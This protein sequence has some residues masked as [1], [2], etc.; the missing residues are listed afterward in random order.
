M[1]G[2]PYHWNTPLNPLLGIP[3]V[4]LPARR[5]WFTAR[6]LRGI[7]IKLRKARVSSI[8]PGILQYDIYMMAICWECG[9]PYWLGVP[10]NS[11]FH[12]KV[13]CVWV[14]C[15][16][17]VCSL[18]KQKSVSTRLSNEI[19]WSERTFL[20]LL[21]PTDRV[22]ECSEHTRTPAAQPVSV[23]WHE[24]PTESPPGGS[25]HE[26]PHLVHKISSKNLKSWE[27]TI[28][29][30]NLLFLRFEII[31]FRFFLYRWLE[32]ISLHSTHLELAD[33]L[34]PSLKNLDVIVLFDL[35]LGLSQNG[36]GPRNPVKTTPRFWNFQD[37]NGKSWQGLM[38]SLFIETY[39]G[40]KSGR[41]WQMSSWWFGKVRKCFLPPQTRS[42]KH[43]HAS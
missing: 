31:S 26:K 19:Q 33:S 4:I 11:T 34:G 38:S 9:L 32:H 37:E 1:L 12:P 16:P 27:K 20:T 14:V 23:T 8:I 2:W 24:N 22:P 36:F 18:W 43:D 35:N 6:K 29:K 40:P 5:S 17:G 13:M 28:C 39:F 41:W 7:P 15:G 3:E 30:G 42:I 10:A 25:Q 21:H